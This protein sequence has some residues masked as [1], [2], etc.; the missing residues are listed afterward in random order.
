MIYYG[1]SRKS[2][3]LEI[4]PFSQGGEGK[5]FDVIGN[6][7]VV[8]KLYKDGK[9]T[10]D[11][12]NKLLTMV[13]NPPSR[14]ALNQIAW[15]LDVLYDGTG[16]FV[17]FIMPKLAKN[18]DL[19][20]IYEYGSTA[21]YAN[22]PWSH[23]I[24]IAI[25]LCAVLHA[26]HSSG[27]VV[28]DFNPKNISVNPSNGLVAFFDADSFH[29]TESYNKVYRC[30]VG[31]PEYLAPE[32][33]RKLKGGSTLEGLPLPT[34]TIDTDRFALAIHIF[35]LLMN[36]THP[37]ACRI[38]PS[39]ASVVCPQPTDNI[40]QGVF[41]FMQRRNDIDIPV[42][43]P[44]I[45]ILPTEVQ[46][47]FRRAF[48]EGHTNPSR[49]PDPE[50]WYNALSKLERATKRCS[51]NNHHVYYSV[52]AECP[53]CKV[54][55]KVNGSLATAHST[56]VATPIPGGIRPTNQPK[57]P[58]S[59]RP[60]ATSTYST[61]LPSS[62]STYSSTTSG[63]T[64]SYSST[65]TSYGFTGE[66]LGFFGKIKYMGISIFALLVGFI[67]SLMAV[68]GG[69][70]SSD[71]GGILTFIQFIAILLL[72]F[73]CPVFLIYTFVKICKSKYKTGFLK[74]LMLMNA[75]IPALLVL[76]IHFL[77][78]AIDGK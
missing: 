43:A 29:I 22:L 67:T 24:H 7:S 51:N 70:G 75:V 32:I 3:N 63:S 34:F 69:I 64:Y 15:P 6:P 21:K 31:M 53:W 56:I 76:A 78:V 71:G 74:I 47:L 16:K 23:K 35:Q 4:Q 13:N 52:L 9:I 49:R 65:K 55:R 73:G 45:E 26:V 36:G 66:R 44:S 10:K 27:H 30:I 61:T 18:E 5:I 77:S 62:T 37:F 57:P 41:P 38:I 8:A 20:V 46:N 14:E 68:G 50:E 40:L 28:G 48:I 58:V 54:D 42:Y 72:L 39:Q 12:E 59:P 60:S 17:G 25:N 11:K 2:Y 33:Q 1:K 19:N